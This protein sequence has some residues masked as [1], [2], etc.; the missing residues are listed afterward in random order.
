MEYQRTYTLADIGRRLD[1]PRTTIN[2]WAYQFREFLPTVGTGRTMRYKE[3]CLEIFGLISK[4]K[5][6]GEPPE[7]IRDALRQI[8]REIIVTDEDDGPK[9]YLAYLADVITGMQREIAD[10]RDRLDD[11]SE[12]EAERIAGMKEQLG[13]IQQ[14]LVMQQEQMQE[15]ATTLSRVETYGKK[16][17]FWSRLWG[18]EQ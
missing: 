18:R 5:D 6:A 4:M 15:I 14:V 9:P 7:L 2:D 3:D 17:S 8:C 10:L 1:R 13:S 12:Q 11:R 16:K